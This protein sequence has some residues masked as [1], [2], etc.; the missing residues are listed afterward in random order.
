MAQRQRGWFHFLASRIKRN[1]GAYFYTLLGVL[2]ALISIVGV[3]GYLEQAKSEIAREA[4]STL[5]THLATASITTSWGSDRNAQEAAGQTILDDYFAGSGIVLERAA[6]TD[7]LSWVATLDSESITSS[8]VE[9][10]QNAER[11]LSERFESAGVSERGLGVTLRSAAFLKQISADTATLGAIGYA[12]IGIVLILIATVAVLLSRLVATANVASTTVLSARGSS[13]KRFFLSGIFEFLIISL[14]AGGA[15]YLLQKPIHSALSL[16]AVDNFGSTV[17]L[18]ISV[19]VV[20]VAFIVGA[21]TGSDAANFDFRRQAKK[22]SVGA[23]LFTIL[24]L[25]LSAAGAWFLLSGEPP[26]LSLQGGELLV[27][28]LLAAA[29]SLLLLGVVLIATLLLTPLLIRIFAFLVRFG[30]ASRI[31]GKQAVDSSTKWRPVML[32]TAISVAT[33]VIAGSFMA[34]WPVQREQSAL[35]NVGFDLAVETSGRNASSLDWLDDVTEFSGHSPA[36]ISNGNV[37]SVTASILAASPDSLPEVMKD[38][39]IAENLKSYFSGEIAYTPL[40]DGAKQLQFNFVSSAASY[41]FPFQGETYTLEPNSLA[42]NPWVNFLLDDGTVA[43]VFINS[44]VFANAEYARAW[45][46]YNSKLDP[47]RPWWDQDIDV[48]WPPVWLPADNV[49]SSFTVDIPE[50]AIGFIGFDLKLDLNQSTHY[51]EWTI[52]LDSITGLAQKP[53]Y[54]ISTRNSAAKEENFDNAKSTIDFL[55][56]WDKFLPNPDQDMFIKFYEPNAN[57]VEAVIT[58]DLANSLSLSVGSGINIQGTGFSRVEAEVVGIVPMIPG[59]GSNSAVLVDLEQISVMDAQITENDRHY[60]NRLL[61]VTDDVLTVQNQL[62]GKSEVVSMTAYESY[63][64]TVGSP[65]HLSLWIAALAAALLALLGYFVAISIDSTRRTGEVRVLKAIGFRDAQV[66]F[67][68]ALEWIGLSVVSIVIGVVAGVVA[69]GIIVI[70][71]VQNLLGKT[72]QFLVEF[73]VNEWIAY[74]TI[75]MVA[76]TVIAAI[77]AFMRTRSAM[78]IREED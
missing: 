68:R 23:T 41:I 7:V 51:G 34:V 56:T 14:L 70:A 54:E 6:S 71:I 19:A 15:A 13:R 42:Y 74:A 38:A 35:E 77:Y 28:P 39:Q 8:G 58:E 65:L 12:P 27:N 44:Q 55:F 11:V 37:N 60:P 78:T 45:R 40:V 4:V 73:T 5:P 29:P 33:G 63:K 57:T 48:D 20:V 16:D 76:A 64:A 47:T 66:R 61:F 43:T 18:G 59:T 72:P 22:V 25:L 26:V 49:R 31:A 9:L 52:R 10:I 69:S 53:S 75:P 17:T 21:W 46:E 36:L 2:L 24:L 30:T 50:N 62:K 3:S 32:L 1:F 67:G